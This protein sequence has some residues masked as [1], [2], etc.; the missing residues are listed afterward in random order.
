MTCATLLNI[1]TD[2]H[3]VSGKQTVAPEIL[4]QFS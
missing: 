2:T 3:T 1:Q 4:L